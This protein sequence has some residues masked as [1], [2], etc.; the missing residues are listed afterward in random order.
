[1][2]FFAS[3]GDDCADCGTSALFSTD[4]HTESLPPSPEDAKPFC[5]ECYVDR[6]E[7]GFCAV[8]RKETDGGTALLVVGGAS[9]EE[10]ESVAAGVADEVTGEKDGALSLTEP[11]VVDRFGVGYV[12]GLCRGVESHRRN[13]YASASPRGTV[14][15]FETFTTEEERDALR[16][17]LAERVVDGTDVRKRADVYD[18]LTES[19]P[20]LVEHS[21]ASRLGLGRRA[22]KV[23]KESGVSR[24]SE[25]SA[26][27]QRTGEEFE[28]YF[29]EWCEDRNL[30]VRPGKPALRRLYPEVGDEVAERTDGLSGVPDFF[31]RGDGQSTFGD[32]EW[33]PDGEAFV[34][35]KYGTGRLSREQQDVV[36]HLKSHGF[37]IYVFREDRDEYRFD[38]R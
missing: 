32:E 13:I 2:A 24:A 8:V 38:K 28:E 6:H 3:E 4:E 16:D 35:V 34:E 19:Y 37:D 14:V 31:V 1:M 15:D 25:R 26:R 29:V 22:W 17:E 20:S 23:A 30:T 36:A 10:A 9:G 5:L 11:E 33:R 21:V 7:L 27:S 12:R 18:A